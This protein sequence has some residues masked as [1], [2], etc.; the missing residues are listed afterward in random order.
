MDRRRPIWHDAGM[1]RR[2]PVIPSTASSGDGTTS[3]QSPPEAALRPSRAPWQSP[4][5]GLLRGALVL[6]AL[7]IAALAVDVPVAAWCKEGHWPAGTPSVLAKIAGEIHR[8]VTLSEVFAHTVSV[9]VILALVLALDPALAWP[10]WRFPA[11]GRPSRQPT[12]AQA[13]FARILGAAFTGGILADLIKLLV[14][15][16]RPRAADFATHT[17][18]WDSFND[19]VIDTITGSSSNVNS[20]PSGHSAIAAGLAAGLAWKY[21]RGRNFFALF[22]LMAASQRIVSSAH[23]PSDA[24]FG[25]ALGLFGAGIVLHSPPGSGSPTA[26]PAAKPRP[27]GADGSRS[28]DAV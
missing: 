12:S 28:P 19:A 18:V 25:L 1:R 9:G 13:D 10:S 21:P 27:V 11:I 2:T 15:R 17:N 14:D 4:V 6:I 22:A 24:C 7:G 16:V 20:F 23:F 3:R 5:P 26:L 8:L